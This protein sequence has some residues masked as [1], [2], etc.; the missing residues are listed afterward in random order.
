VTQPA[1]DQ[2]TIRCETCPT[3][4][5]AGTIPVATGAELRAARLFAGL[6][7]AKLAVRLGG[8]SAAYISDLEREE[9]TSS[10]KLVRAWLEA[11]GWRLVGPY[12]EAPP[13]RG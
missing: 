2:P 10:P 6:S 8:V 3:C 1:A 13:K 7:Q 12:K 4:L 9:R 11:C 5:G